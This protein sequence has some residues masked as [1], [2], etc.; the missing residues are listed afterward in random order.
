MSLTCVKCG[1]VKK[2]K[3]LGGLRMGANQPDLMLCGTCY[4]NEGKR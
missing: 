3:Y 2:D 1:V 4:N